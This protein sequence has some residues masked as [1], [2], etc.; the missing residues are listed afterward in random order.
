MF[1]LFETPK[2]TDKVQLKDS[3]KVVIGSGTNLERA[4]QIGNFMNMLYKSIETKTLE[5]TTVHNLC[6]NVENLI[7]KLSE[8]TS[9]IADKQYYTLAKEVILESITSLGK[10][11][12]L[13]YSLTKLCEGCSDTALDLEEFSSVLELT[14]KTCYLKYNQL[15]K[16]LLRAFPEYFKFI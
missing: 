16:E 9:D 4:F 7:D 6:R 12:E 5:K 10:E 1:S 8:E 2:P 11:I 3:T 14:H 13:T 15:L